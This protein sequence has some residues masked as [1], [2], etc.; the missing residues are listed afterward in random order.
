MIQTENHLIKE[1]DSIKSALIKLNELGVYLTLFA[2]DEDRKLV[3]TLTDGDIRRA[4]IQ[5]IPVSEPVSKAM[6]R[7]FFYLRKNKFSLD[8]IQ[9]IKELQLHLVPYLDEGGKL[10]K[11]INFDSKKSFLPIDAFIMAGGKGLRLRPLTLN[12]PKP[13]LKVGNK[14]IMERNLDLLCNFGIQNAYISINYLGEQIIEYFQH[15]YKGEIKLEYVREGKPLG[16]LGSMS[17]VDGFENDYILLMN[18]DLL[19]N[20]DLEDFFFDF[21]KSDA[22]MAIATVPYKVDVP[23]A[24]LETSNNFVSNLKEKPSYT[25]YSNGGIYL[26]K[27]ELTKLVPFDSFYNA[28]DL[29]ENLI[30]SKMKVLSYPLRSYWLDIGKHEDF[31]KAQEDVKHI[32]F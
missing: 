32:K 11:I 20:I 26:I 16:T 27:R 6:H 22:A 14:P 5:D 7:D 8:A 17:L 13:L 24:V 19:T 2:V 10:L 28:T 25:Y 30:A 15:D 4:L 21:L 12:V 18:S 31:E 23:Y 1:T 29:V 3:G 9:Q